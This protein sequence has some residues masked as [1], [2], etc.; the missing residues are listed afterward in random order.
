MS[1]W[2]TLDLVYC[3]LKSEHSNSIEKNKQEQKHEHFHS[4]LQGRI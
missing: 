1:S 3:N 2:G 4:V